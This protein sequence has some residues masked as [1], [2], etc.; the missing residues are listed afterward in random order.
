MT[1]FIVPFLTPCEGGRRARSRGA[2]G[3]P[4]RLHDLAALGG[5][6]LCGAGFGEA[7]ALAGVLP[8]AG[9]VGALAGALALAGIRPAA[10]HGVGGKGCRGKGGGREDRGRGG[11]Q[12]AL[13]HG[14]L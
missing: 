11:N 13:V 4:S 2:P 8:L 9:V 5:A 6:V 10:L 14:V 1:A 7:L 12:R 3:C